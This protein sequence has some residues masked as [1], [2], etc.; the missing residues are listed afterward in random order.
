MPKNKKIG[1]S[2]YLSHEVVERK[3]YYLRGGKVMLDTDLAE[4]YQVPTRTLIQAVKRNPKRFPN[5]FMYKLTNNEVTNLRSQSVISSWGGRRYLPY[6]FTEHGVAMLSSV[7]SSDRAIEVNIEIIRAFIRLRELAL[8][9][10]DLRIK[11]DELEKKYDQQFQVVFKAVKALL[12][13]N[14]TPPKRFDA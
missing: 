14:D 12:E 13:K 10:K 1:V 5:D 4:L 8:T 11:I 3:I 6:A 9:H 2:T 7:L